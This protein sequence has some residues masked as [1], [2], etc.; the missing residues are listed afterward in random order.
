MKAFSKEFKIKVLTRVANG[1]RITHVAKD[2]GIS[3]IC[4]RMWRKDQTVG[5][6]THP[7]RPC[8][9]K[10]NTRDLS[11]LKLYGM[12]SLA[13]IGNLHGI[14]KQRVFSIVK[15][16]TGLGFELTPALIPGERLKVGEKVY[17]VLRVYDRWTGAV[18]V[19]G[20]V[21]DPFKWIKL[22]NKAIRLI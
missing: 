1:E 18:E 8:H 19:G 10:P 17:T 22:G 6:K 5:I 21:L 20:K 3:A 7:G 9:S 13:D 14:T 12:H 4:I 2:V 11:I 16:W 15:H